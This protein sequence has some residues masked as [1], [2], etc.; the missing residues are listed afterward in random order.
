MRTM[1]GAA[2]TPRTAQAASQYLAAVRTFAD[3]VLKHGRDVYGPRPTPLFVDGVNIDTLEPVKW[4]STDGTE[5]VLSDLG[6]QQVLFRVL[7]GLT[8]LTG[9]TKYRQAAVDATKYALANLR[10]GGLLAWGGHMAY[11]ASAGKVVWAEDKGKV[12]ELKENY[13]YYQLMWEIDPDAAR[14]VIENI[15]SGHILDWSNL[16]FNR[17]ATPKPPGRLWKNEY[18]GGE[19]F[20]WGKGLTFI[21]AGSDLYYA[22]AMLSKFTADPEP[23]TWAKRLAR[24]YVETRNPKTGIG[25]YQFSQMASAW[26]DDVG[27]IRGD[28]AQYQFAEYFPGHKVVEGTLFP[29]YGDAPGVHPRIVQM[30]LGELLGVAGGE[31]TQWAVEELTAWAKS[32]YRE[33]DNSFV[34]MLTDGTSME[35]F[36]VRKDGY[37]GPKGR[38]L[39]AGRARAS[40]FWAYAMASRLSGNPLM[41]QMARRIALANGFG[42]IEAKADVRT[43]T[44][45]P[46]ALFGFLELHRGTGKPVHLEMATRIGDNILHEQFQKG[47]FV[48][49]RNHYVARFDSVGALALLHLA[50]ALDGK[51]KLVPPYVGTGAFFAAAYDGQ[52]HKYDSSILY[53]RTRSR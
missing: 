12:H 48:K 8:K 37:F 29:T 25:G 34:P 15:W 2:L 36:V 52:G 13:P 21:N 51:P 35:G 45:D 7:D 4:K 33:K 44:S 30:Q 32:A 14:S 46:D 42:D 28:R 9:E 47:F 41:R 39:K 49:S 27:K 18:K 16:D 1:C 24:R 26:C 6:N 20:F 19:V 38:V 23:L 3:N 10:S 50:A 22:A 53:G 5:W 31:F 43:G 40:H 11:N 17:H